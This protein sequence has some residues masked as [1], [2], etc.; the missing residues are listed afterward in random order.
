MTI[1]STSYSVDEIELA[2]GRLFYVQHGRNVIDSAILKDARV[3][4]YIK[5]GRYVVQG[6]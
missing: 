6:A 3:Q 5:Q 4:Q 2:D 1:L